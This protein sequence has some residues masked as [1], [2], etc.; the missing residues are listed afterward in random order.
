MNIQLQENSDLLNLLVTDVS[1]KIDFYLQQ[2]P[3]ELH[4]ILLFDEIKHPH[5]KAEYLASRYAL[6]L[7]KGDEGIIQLKKN[8]NGKPFIHEHESISITHSAQHVAVLSVHSKSCGIDTEVIHPRVKKIASRFLSEEEKSSLISEE[9]IQMLTLLWSAKESVYKCFG[10]E[11]ISFDSN[12]SFQLPEKTENQKGIL[13]G[14]IIT[15]NTPTAV[16][17]HFSF[18]DDSVLTYIVC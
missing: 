9:D 5:K 2:I 6:W 13:S 17:V 4:R 12:I 16:Q 18:I 3:S 1:V 11:T 8:D 10:N 7:L 15:N 14:K